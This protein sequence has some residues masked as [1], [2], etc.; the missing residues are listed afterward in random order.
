MVNGNDLKKNVISQLHQ[1]IMNLA[2]NAY[3]ALTKRTGRITVSL[4]EIEVDFGVIE[5]SDRASGPVA[6]LA[7]IDLRGDIRIS[8]TLLGRGGVTSL[9]AARWLAGRLGCGF[10][11]APGLGATRASGGRRRRWCGMGAGGRC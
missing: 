4:D 5:Q 11:V 6:G 2:T 8:Q 1:V 7:A 10:R 3:Q 9:R